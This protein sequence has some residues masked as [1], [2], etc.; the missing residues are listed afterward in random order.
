MTSSPFNVTLTSFKA[1]SFD[2]YATLIDWETGIFDVLSPLNDRL[3]PEHPCK[4]D[5]KTLLQMYTRLEG[6]LEHQHPDMRYNSLLGL[7]YKAIATELE[8]VDAISDDQ[9]TKEMDAFGNSVGSWPA[10]PDTV[11]ALR[12]LGKY[13][14]LVILSNVDNENIEQTR[15]G[16]LDSTH[17]DAIYTAQEIGSYKPDL[18]NFEY[19]VEH[20]KKE[21]GIGREQILHTAQ[22]LRHDHVPAKK[23]GLATCWIER[24]GDEAVIGGKIADFVNGEIELAFRYETLGAMAE[25][26]EKAFRDERR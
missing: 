9:M 8:V 15:T 22:A 4:G 5:R 13:Y 11:A 24:R 20:A 7:V 2:V 18:R 16:P 14:K 21:M 19:M 3:P 12:T 17:F 23:A 1:L 6:E 25:A 26:V 10:F